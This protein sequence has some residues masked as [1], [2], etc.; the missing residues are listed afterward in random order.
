M[1]SLHS[2]CTLHRDLKPDNILIYKNEKNKYSIKIGD[3]GAVA[4]KV[5]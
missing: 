3:M 2:S 5:Q 4:F 1:N